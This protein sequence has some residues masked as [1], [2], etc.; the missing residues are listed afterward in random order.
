MTI[1]MMKRGDGIAQRRELGEFVRAQ[2]ERLSPAAIGLSAGSRRRTPGLRREEVAQLC[3]LSAT[4]YTWIE[5]GREVSASPAAL[6]RLAG[7]LRLGRAERA[8]LFE[9]AGKRDPEPSAEAAEEPPAAALRCVEAI[10][11]PAYIL[12]RSWNARSWNAKAER[13]FANWLDREGDRNLL[14]FIFLEPSS[15]SLICDWE[16]RARRVAAEFRAARRP[17]RRCRARRA[18]RR[19]AS[20]K[21]GFRAILGRAHGAREGGR[22]AQLQ[23]SEGRIAALRAG[24]LRS[25][26]AFPFQV[27]DAGRG[28]L[29]RPCFA[30]RA[31]RG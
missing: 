15:R 9:L 13:L 25:R 22:R 29:R 10:S 5:Q 11:S 19:A 31:G 23:P 12:D 14:R 27:D 16:E 18:D 28:R 26:G 20:G 3:G 8:Y 17:H 4:W 7:A 21:P 24:R 2:R 6:A 1:T 30:R